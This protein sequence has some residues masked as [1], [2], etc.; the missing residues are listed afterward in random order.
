MIQ[1]RETSQY[2]AIGHPA[3]IQDQ[4]DHDEHDNDLG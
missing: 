2:L 4:A 3:E 1:G